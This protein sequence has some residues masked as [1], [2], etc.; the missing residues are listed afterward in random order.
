MCLKMSM[1]CSTQKKELYGKFSLPGLSRSC[2]AVD[3]HVTL[4]R[5]KTRHAGRLLEEPSRRQREAMG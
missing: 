4:E 5:A 1:K 3:L 2:G